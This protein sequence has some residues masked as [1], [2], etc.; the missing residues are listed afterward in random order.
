MTQFCSLFY[1][2]SVK[3]YGKIIYFIPESIEIKN[4]LKLCAEVYNNRYVEEAQ[5]IG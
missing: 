2:E 4:N 5:G 3:N 1:R